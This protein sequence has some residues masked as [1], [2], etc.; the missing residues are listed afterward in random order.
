MGLL[1]DR[2]LEAAR[3]VV[4]DLLDASSSS[5]SDK[6]IEHAVRW[7]EQTAPP[8]PVEVTLPWEVEPVGDF[9]AALYDTEAG[10]E[11]SARAPARTQALILHGRAE[12]QWPE[13]VTLVC[14]RQPRGRVVI[15]FYPDPQAAPDR[16]VYQIGRDECQEL[17]MIQE[18]QTFVLTS[19]KTV[20]VAPA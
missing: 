15:R 14:T 2:E 1:T 12:L 18:G 16:W 19:R 6:A 5:Q 10:M 8:P 3:Q 20:G 11:I 13:D 7:L 4:S 17:E 9:S